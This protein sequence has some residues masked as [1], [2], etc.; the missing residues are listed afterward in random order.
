MN[1]NISFLSREADPEG[2]MVSSFSF[3]V[4]S[5]KE[6]AG[7]NNVRSCYVAVAIALDA[8]ATGVCCCF[9]L[10]SC[11]F[12]LFSLASRQLLNNP[13][14]WVLKVITGAF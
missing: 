11:L 8:A 2:A 10:F 14:W 5:G 12:L 6:L 13:M 3:I 9:P 1:G 7:G 4:C